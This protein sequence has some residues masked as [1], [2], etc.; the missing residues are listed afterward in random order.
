[1]SS[2]EALFQATFR[3]TPPDGS[4]QRIVPLQGH[5]P[6][7]Q[8]S[9][10]VDGRLIV[11]RLYRLPSEEWLLLRRNRTPAEQV[12]DRAWW[13]SPEQAKLWRPHTSQLDLST[14][15]GW[16][17]TCLDDALADA[18]LGQSSNHTLHEK[19]LQP[20]ARPAGEPAVLAEGASSALSEYDK[21]KY[22]IL[23]MIDLAPVYDESGELLPDAAPMP[24]LR[25][26]TT[27]KFDDRS[28]TPEEDE[29]RVL[30]EVCKATPMTPELW[31]RFAE[32]QRIPW[33][34]QSIERLKGSTGT[35]DVT[36]GSPASAQPHRSAHAEEM[37][38]QPNSRP[39]QERDTGSNSKLL[40]R[41][42][43][44]IARPRHLALSVLMWMEPFLADVVS[45][46][47]ATRCVHALGLLGS[48]VN[49]Y[50]KNRFDCDA[51]LASYAEVSRQPVTLVGK[52]GTSATDWALQY[53]CHVVIAFTL[54]SK[55]ALLHSGTLPEAD[56][57]ALEAQ[58]PHLRQLIVSQKVRLP[59]W[60]D[61]QSLP[62]EVEWEYAQVRR[63]HQEDTGAIAQRGTEG[64]PP[65]AVE[66]DSPA[67]G[68]TE[69]VEPQDHA[70]DSP[71]GSPGQR[72]EGANLPFVPTG[73]QEEILELLLGKAQTLDY[74]AEKLQVDRS[75]LHRSAIKEL[76]ELDLIRNHR[77]VGGYYRP[78]NPPPKY[79]E[80]LKEQG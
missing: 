27:W 77:R 21:L 74:L 58:W 62:A 34:K 67:A 19:S 15:P 36:E 16:M 71:S 33:L 39:V 48:I 60:Q 50:V 42:S 59:A 66:P 7:G 69:G 3:L 61:L 72:D 55:V 26:T 46:Q 31:M 28:T 11:T 37:R 56:R 65:L 5:L 13:L 78:D 32:D 14:L 47:P 6:Q 80:W 38:S 79:A 10:G 57:I 45:P 35:L 64:E 70:G 41:P 2:E 73:S 12:Y 8:E 43:P 52:H 53:A 17:V 63:R 1:M 4:C 75:S 44:N 23:Q 18:S 54:E 40:N 51:A 24:I 29:Q 25:P 30:V 49:A 68:A 76:M 20:V 22:R 9:T